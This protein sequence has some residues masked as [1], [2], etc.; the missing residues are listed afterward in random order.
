MKKILYV[1]ALLI[2]VGFSSCLK[3]DAIVGPNAPGYISNV[4]EF[5]NATAPVSSTTSPVVVFVP[6]T[7]EV[8]PESEFEIIISYSGAN[9]APQDITVELNVA[10]DAIAKYNAA[11]KANL[12]SLPSGTYE[13]PST[14]TIKKG[15]KRAHVKV[16]VLPEKLDQTV[17][18]ALAI[19][20]TS[21]SFGTISGNFGTAIF[22]LPIKSVWEGTYDFYTNNNYGSIDGNI[23]EFSESGVVMSTVGPNRLRVDYASRTYGGYTEY[24]F[25]G[26]NTEITE[27]A[28]NSGG[29]R[30][31]K[32]DEIIKLDPENG[33]IEIR[34]TWFGRGVLERWKKTGE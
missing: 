4:I 24:Q 27:I 22:N 21:S 23:G 32:I 2:S 28:V 5:Y 8:V 12:H 26:D 6:Q 10:P 34:Y 3:D 17:S 19:A 29:F 11:E 18:N 15:E 20:I 1:F 30:E 14:V 9:V 31:V 16:K 25:N 13:I 7:L 33:I